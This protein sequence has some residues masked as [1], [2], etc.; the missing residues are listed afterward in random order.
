MGV[1]VARLF[2]LTLSPIPS[3][4]VLCIYVHKCRHNVVFVLVCVQKVGGN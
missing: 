1:F 2:S 4:C 3:V